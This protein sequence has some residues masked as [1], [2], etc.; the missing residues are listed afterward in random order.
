MK[1]FMQVITPHSDILQGNLTM[2][3]FAADLW[4]VANG[5][6]PLDYQ[7]ADIFFKKTYITKGLKN[8]LEITHNR[9]KGKGGDSVI[10]LQTPFG[11]GKTHTLIALFHKAKEWGASAVVFDGTAL[12]PQD[13]KP[14][15]E[16]EKQL[17]GKVE[18]TK[19]DV[20]PGK[21]KLITLLS[22]NSPV[23]ILMD[24]ILEYA[25][26]AAGIKIGDSNLA[27]QTLAFIQE[28]MGAV[29]SI[30]NA[31]LVITLPSSILE[32]YDKNAEKLYQQLQKVT[33]RMERI[34]TPVGED[35]IEDVI[36][37]RLFQDPNEKQVKN[38]VDKFVDYAKNEGLLSSDDAV[39]YRERFLRSYP[40][41]PE[42]IDILYKRWGSFPTFQRTRGVLRLLSL[43]VY[44]LKE[45]KLP[46]IRIGDFD[47]ANNDIRREIIKH[48]GP[49]YDS[50]VS[51]DI[52]SEDAGAKL[53]DTNIGN[54]FTAFKLG[55][56]VS[57]TIFMLSFSGGPDKGGSLKEIK[58]YSTSVDFP[59]NVIDTVLNQLK[60]RLFYLADEG[61][62]FTDQPNINKILV[63]REE[64]ILQR[65]ISE[66][67]RETIRKYLSGKNSK[68]SIY[69]WPNS[70]KDVPD[71]SSLKLAILQLS[72]PDK[73]FIEKHGESPRVYRNTLIFLCPVPEYEESFYAFIRE[74]LALK[75]IDADEKLNLTDNQKK[76]LRKKIKS[77]EERKLEEVRKFYRKVF[78]PSKDGFRSID[79]GIPTLGGDSYIDS[80]IYN[81]LKANGEIL[82]KLS[83]AII[84]TKYLSNNEE[85]VETKKIFDA[86]MKTPGEMRIVSQDALKIGI[87]EGIEKGIFGIG[88]LE[89]ETHKC[90]HIKEHIPSTLAEGEI[91]IKAELCEKNEGQGS[92]APSQSSAGGSGKINEPSHGTTPVGGT[93]ATAQKVYKKIHLK[94]RPQVGKLADIVRIVSYLKTQFSDCEVKIEITTRDGSIKT[95]DYE[96]KIEEALKQ[97]NTQIEEEDKE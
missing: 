2:D 33:G 32:H 20:S 43:I 59:S 3:V 91:I 4:Q 42:V 55:T 35:E 74:F 25:T 76:E 65:D 10:Q 86:L 30:G 12:S 14:W 90:E 16:L 8:I 89:N 40:F 37:R 31:L 61:L 38:I 71:S 63:N 62:Y 15:E 26:K 70:H 67:E 85:Y 24:E 96:D 34:Y 27:S 28:L 54:A 66:Y 60:E 68:F 56:V 80:E 19:G 72:K 47:L 21:D 6:A 36:R 49:E 97:S 41:K 87:D 18:L 78:V 13:A 73:L 95:S 11:G 29:A 79:L 77:F 82:E 45:K 5:D 44:N 57:T 83:P 50:I 51:Q 64:S 39:R 22:K 9:L 69:L 52:T 88:H 81:T 7:D 48:I 58:L 75:S 53:V 46:F 92:S 94:L 93:T 17:T 23:L 84:K 1:Q